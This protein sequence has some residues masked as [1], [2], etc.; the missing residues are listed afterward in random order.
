MNLRPHAGEWDA[1]KLENFLFDMKPYF[2]VLGIDSKESQLNRTTMFLT[3]MVKVWWR[4]RYHKI[5]KGRCHISTW[6]ELKKELKVHFYY[7][8]FDYLAMRKLR[9]LR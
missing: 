1:K 8:N 6:E 9:D 2:L 7:E 4:I 3:N 5:Q